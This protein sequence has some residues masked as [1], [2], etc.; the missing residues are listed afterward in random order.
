LLDALVVLVFDLAAHPYQLA[1]GFGIP[2]SRD[3][4][5]VLVER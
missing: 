5:A 4:S 1:A 3:V 2:H